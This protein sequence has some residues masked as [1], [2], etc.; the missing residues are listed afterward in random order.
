[1]Q[2]FGHV[3]LLHELWQ[4]PGLEAAPSRAMRSSRRRFDA[5]A[6]VR[7]M[8]FNRLCEPSSKLGVLRWLEIVSLPEAPEKV[9]HDQLLR[10][11]DALMEQIDAVEKAL[12]AGAAAPARRIRPSPAPADDDLHRLDRT[13]DAQQ[14]A[15]G[16]C[17]VRGDEKGAVAGD[18]FPNLQRIVRGGAHRLRFQAE[19]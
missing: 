6:L 10:S 4:S 8:V 2:A 11:M 3:Y 16:H 19:T 5:A 14:V 17:G 1:M 12:A 15:A 13:G 9:T 18:G 7:A